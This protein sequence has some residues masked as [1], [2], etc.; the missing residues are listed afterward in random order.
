LGV[1]EK[2]TKMLNIN[3]F[4]VIFISF[5]YIYNY[6]IEVINNITYIVK[7][8]LLSHWCCTKSASNANRPINPRLI[9]YKIEDF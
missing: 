9:G 5:L 2:K 7:R 6:F 4:L 1:E 3:M 8:A